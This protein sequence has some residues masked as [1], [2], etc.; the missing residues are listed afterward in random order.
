[1]RTLSTSGVRLLCLTGLLAVGC[2]EVIH[3]EE[4]RTPA[5]WLRLAV[6]KLCGPEPLTG[7]MA[8]HQLNGAWFLEE[9]NV[10][11]HGRSLRLVQKFLLP[12]GGELHVTRFQPGGRLRR[13]SVE[14]HATE[15]GKPVPRLWA[16]ADANCTLRAGRRIVSEKQGPSVSLEHLDIDLT[17]VR[18]TEKLQT[19]WP[20]GRDLGGPRVALIDTG[21]A[22]DLAIY[23]E[24]LARDDDG[25]PLGY[26]YWDLDKWPYDGD[27]SRGPFTPV[28]HGS[29]VASIVVREAPKATLI[30]LRYPRPDMRRMGDAVRRAAR[31]GARIVAMP[32]GSRKAGDWETF[33][34]AA[35]AHPG[36][37]F[38]V[39]AG[40]DGRN[41]DKTKLWPAALDLPNLIV[42]T[43]SDAFGRLAAGSNWGR[44]S[45]DIMLPAENM[46]VIDF[47]GAKG[48]ASGSSYAVPRLAA[49]AARI[50][51]DE[52]TLSGNELKT[53]IFSRAVRSP[54]EDDVVAVGW[55]PDPLRDK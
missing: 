17:T 37:L 55:I 43:S 35:N 16:S 33:E 13:F 40:N 49:M 1:M 42:V 10:Q 38:I 18:W 9:R 7:L 24:R 27:A 36:L 12:R 52:P 47:R 32:L 5:N 4:I 11:R 15:G 50:L 45:V 14:F 41:I 46:P 31:A 26:D 21:L 6:T 51:T 39:S 22:Y 44:T 53:R 19:P 54:Y 30:P 25:T 34:K 8:Q 20:A 3:G 28:R 2:G 23:R 29:A 48:K